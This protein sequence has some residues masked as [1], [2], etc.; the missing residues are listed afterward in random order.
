MIKHTK[1][2]KEIENNA[3]LLDAA[4]A[5]IQHISRICRLVGHVRAYA[6]QEAR[7]FGEDTGAYSA[8]F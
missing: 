3:K 4:H 1:R 8:I 2:E 5:E 7:R 6:L